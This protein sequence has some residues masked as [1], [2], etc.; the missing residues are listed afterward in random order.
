MMGKLLPFM[1]FLEREAGFGFDIEKFEHRL[2]LQKYVFISKFFGFNHGYS[3]SIYLR[4]PY[5]PALADDYYKLADFYSSYDEDYTKELGGLN[6][7][8]FL[9]VIAGKDGKWLEIAATILSVYES[10]RIK[11]KGAELRERVISTSCD[12]KSATE[13]GKIYY[14][15]DELKRVGLIDA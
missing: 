11:F 4:G 12:I 13:A 10:Y 2:M 5:S 14:V 3:Y 6:T 15:F 1:K 9:K 8:K 7:E